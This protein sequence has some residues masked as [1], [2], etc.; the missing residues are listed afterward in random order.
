[1]PRVTILLPTNK[2]KGHGRRL[3]PNNGT[4]HTNPLSISLELGKTYF[5]NEIPTPLKNMTRELE[6]TSHKSTYHIKELHR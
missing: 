1:M 5:G 3:M 4:D 6:D 2:L